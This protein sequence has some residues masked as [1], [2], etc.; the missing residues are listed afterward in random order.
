MFTV[1]KEWLNNNKT[2]AGGYKRIQAE[3]LGLDWPLPKGWKSQIIGEKID[4]TAKRTVEKHSEHGGYPL[5]M[6][7][8]GM[9]KKLSRQDK[10]TVYEFLRKELSK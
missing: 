7:V 5:H 10:A 2:K 1:T 6:R 3:A 8:M 9:I 4:L